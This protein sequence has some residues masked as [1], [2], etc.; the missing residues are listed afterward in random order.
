MESPTRSTLA[1]QC[2]NSEISLFR[3]KEVEALQQR[4][5]RKDLM[6]SDHPLFGLFELARLN[7]GQLA[8][9][10]RDGTHLAKLVAPQ[11]QLTLRVLTYQS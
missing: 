4:V 9:P 3:S 11:N 5:A 2:P 8:D 7:L 10:L 1:H 6:E